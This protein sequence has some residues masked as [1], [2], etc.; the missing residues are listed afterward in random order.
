[1]EGLFVRE[2]AEALAAEGAD[3]RVAHVRNRLVWPFSCLKPQRP[4]SGDRAGGPVPVY[5]HEVR[6]WPAA[7]GLNRYARRLSLDLAAR[8]EREWPDFRP[9]LIYA[10]TIIPGAQV[11]LSVRTIS[12]VRSSRRRTERTRGSGCGSGGV[13]G[14]SWRQG[15]AACRSSA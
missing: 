5:R 6:G 13:G 12:L 4:P 14:P 3:V 11:G 15:G 1:M 9:D 10:H 7:L 2:Q 8:L